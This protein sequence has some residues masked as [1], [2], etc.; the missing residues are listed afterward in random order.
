LSICWRKSNFKKT[1]IR[2]KFRDKFA[3][4][5]YVCAENLT[6][7]LMT[8]CALNRKFKDQVEIDW[9]NIV[10]TPIKKKG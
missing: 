8:L 7:E 10:E 2:K 1:K 4:N 9:K 3:D 5:H 6:S